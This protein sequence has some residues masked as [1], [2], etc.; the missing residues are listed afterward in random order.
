M[1]ETTLPVD[2]L[3]ECSQAADDR[4]LERRLR[5]LGRLVAIVLC[6]LHAWV[7]RHTMNPDG[8][9][10]LDVGDAYGRGDWGNALNTY[11]SPL[12]CWILE[13]ALALVRPTPYWECAVVH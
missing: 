2:P 11:W 12:Y 7:A 10:Y 4:R 1:K 13:G 5:W 9:S 6:G 3:Q 8:I